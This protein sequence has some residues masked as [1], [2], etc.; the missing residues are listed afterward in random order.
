MRIG[1]Y[2]CFDDGVFIAS[3][4][5]FCQERKKSPKTPFETKVSK[6]PLRGY[7]GLSDLCGRP[8]ATLRPA[9]GSASLGV[10][11]AAV[12]G[13]AY[14]SVSGF[15]ADGSVGKAPRKEKDG[16]VHG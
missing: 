13:A 4:G 7:R 9:A 5:N 2:P 1:R 11:P 6:F 14:S 10:I 16:K 15:P 3:Q 12:R 8:S